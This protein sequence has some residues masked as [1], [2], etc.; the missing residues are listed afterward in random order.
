[1]AVNI[2]LKYLFSD[3]EELDPTGLP[4][5]TTLDFISNGSHIYGEIL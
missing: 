2:N 5:Y 1:M 3:S 4:D